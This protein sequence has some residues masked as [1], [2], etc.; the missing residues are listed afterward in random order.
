VHAA[1]ET[2][3]E[4]FAMGIFGALTTAVTGLKAQSFALENISGNIA[5]S[6]TTAFKRVDTS[7]QDLIPDNPPSK[8][9]SGTVTASARSTNAVQGD[10]QSASIGTF[11]AINGDGFF[12]VGKPSS[13]VDN[14]PVFDGVERYTRRGDFQPDKNGFLVNGAGYYLE[15]I[16]VDPTTGNLVGSVP[17][18]LQFQN[19]FLPAQQTT[20]IDYRANLASYPLTQAHDTS[21][22]RSELI[23]P[24]TLSANP[25]AGAPVAAKITGVGAALADVIATVTGTGTFAT[26]GTAL[27]AGNGGLLRLV[28]TPSGGSPTTYD[29]N[30]LATDTLTNVV[31]TINTTAGLSS[32]VVAS[33][34]TSGGTNKLVLTSATADYDFD[35]N[36]ASTDTLTTRLGLDEVSHTSK[37]LM[38]QGVSG[39]E[40]L[41]VTVGSNSFSLTFGTG[42]GQIST[43]AELQT[44]LAAYPATMGTATADTNGNLTFTASGTNTVIVSPAATAAKFGINVF[45]AYPANGTVLGQDSDAFLNESLGGGAITAFDISGSPVNIQLRWAKVD[46]S[47][48]G[49]TDTWNLFYLVNSS[50]TGTQPAW[51]NAGVNYTFGAN[52]Q[53]SPSIGTL[54]LNNVTVNGVALGNIQLVHG[55][56][57]ITQFSDPNGGVKVNLLQQNGFPAGEL[58]KIAVG[59]NGRV[60]GSYSNGRTLE[61]ADIT[62]A[63]FN[64]TNYLKRIDGGAFEVTDGSGPAI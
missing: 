7:F 8:Q 52:G 38:A 35:V 55:T 54:T 17:Q 41:N 26:A 56:G 10:F 16:P 11:M 31:N 21:I 49:G 13:V 3:L 15:G 12:V 57:G 62:L 34:D 51:Q 24:V 37:N 19:D 4:G 43:V 27:G 53:M 48:Y 39:G 61:L 50:A 30:F 2:G 59:S 1:R 58:Q 60:I 14:R 33:I 28:A 42:G 45:T 36:I 23:D 46:S 5:N 20:Q 63:A 25:I 47:A 22:P 6:Q 64:G 29:L 9:L 40:V 32:A 44:A 18:L